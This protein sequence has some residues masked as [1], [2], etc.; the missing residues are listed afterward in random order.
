MAYEDDIHLIAAPIRLVRNLLVV[1]A[2]ILA[3]P[4]LLVWL[5][6]ASYFEP[7]LGFAKVLIGVFGPIVFSIWFAGV[8]RWS[9]QGNQRYPALG[10]GCGRAGALGAYFCGLAWVG[11]LLSIMNS[12]TGLQSLWAMVLGLFSPAIFYVLGRT[13]GMWLTKTLAVLEIGLT[14]FL[15]GKGFGLF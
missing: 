12:L 9:E 14:V 3:A 11:I 1:S 2:F 5:V 13:F 8:V 15:F 10:R 4:L 7:H 6:V